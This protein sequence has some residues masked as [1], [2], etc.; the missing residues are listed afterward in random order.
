MTSRRK[1]PGFFVWLGVAAVCIAPQPTP[2]EPWH[3]TI[4][5]PRINQQANFCLEKTE[6]MLV[7]EVFRRFGPRP[8]YAALSQSSACARRVASFTPKAVVARVIISEGE[9]GEYIVSFVRVL[10]A[11]GNVEYLVT[12]RDVRD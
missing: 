3:Y 6:A 11:D 10:T 2:A 7:A 12:T 8:G 9:A 5:Q 1:S 4:D